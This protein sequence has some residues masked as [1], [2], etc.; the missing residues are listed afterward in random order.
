MKY[1]FFHI[2]TAFFGIIIAQN[3][4]AVNSRGLFMPSIYLPYIDKKEALCYNQ[5]ALKIQQKGA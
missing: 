2:R 5:G 3:Q 1:V 4:V